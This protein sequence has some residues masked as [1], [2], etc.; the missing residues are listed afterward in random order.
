MRPEVESVAH[1]FA[2]VLAA[3]L[4]LAVAMTAWSCRSASRAAPTTTPTAAAS[5]DVRG[6]V[7]V[8]WPPYELEDL[9]RAQWRGAYADSY[10][11]DRVGSPGSDAFLIGSWWALIDWCKDG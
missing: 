4:A 8:T 1:G 9:H 5:P 2:R 10:R 6:R 3:L 7:E 11:G